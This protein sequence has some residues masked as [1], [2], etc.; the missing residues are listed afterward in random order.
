MIHWSRAQTRRAD[1][2]PRCGPSFCCKVPLGTGIRTGLLTSLSNFL[3]QPVQV[4]ASWH[5]VCYRIEIGENLEPYADMLSRACKEASRPI[6]GIDGRRLVF[7]VTRLPDEGTLIST[8]TG[9]RGYYPMKPTGPNPSPRAN[10]P[11][12]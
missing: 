1:S 9:S 12:G 3:Y 10:R 11:D 4:H 2:R 5:R 8:K 7:E 6:L